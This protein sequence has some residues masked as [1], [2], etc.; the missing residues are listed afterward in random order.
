MGFTQDNDIFVLTLLAIYLGLQGFIAFNHNKYRRLSVPV[1]VEIN[2]DASLTCKRGKK[3]FFNVKMFQKVKKKEIKIIK[4][5]PITQ[6]ISYYSRN[7]LLLK[8]YPITQETSYY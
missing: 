6:E 1:L 4:K 8:K 7:I 2:E 3:N 5:Y